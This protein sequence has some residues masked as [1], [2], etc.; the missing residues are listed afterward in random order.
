MTP[1][2]RIIANASL[3][4]R[5]TFGVPARAPWL[6]EVDDA[7]AHG[8]LPC[9]LDLLAADIARGG[10]ALGERTSDVGVIARRRSIRLDHRLGSLGG[11]HG[12]GQIPLAH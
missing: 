4:E 9:A 12:N 5:T 7:A 1:G 3:R 2:Y 6:I 10:Q 8:E 11:I